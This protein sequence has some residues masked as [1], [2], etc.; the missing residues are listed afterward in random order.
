MNLWVKYFY[1]YIDKRY[2]VCW[3]F[4]EC[5]PSSNGQKSRNQII[6]FCKSH[7]HVWQ[8]IKT[9]FEKWRSAYILSSNLKIRL[10]CMNL[11][12]QGMK[13]LGKEWHN[14]LIR[15]KTLANSRPYFLHIFLLL[16][17]LLN[18]FSPYYFSIFL[19]DFLGVFVATCNA[20]FT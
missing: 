12:R 1:R 11:P 7:F 13:M 10:H 18:W 6:L 8:E 14:I 9:N 16:L 17:L 5:I 20:S 19:F 3:E 4:P 2:V 15:R